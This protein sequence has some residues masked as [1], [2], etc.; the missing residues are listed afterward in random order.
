MS[1]SAKRQTGAWGN[2]AGKRA[3]MHKGNAPN[4]G[5]GKVH[6]AGYTY[7]NFAKSNPKVGGR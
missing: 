4:P 7:A 6:D 5:Q 2:T 3:G 1:K